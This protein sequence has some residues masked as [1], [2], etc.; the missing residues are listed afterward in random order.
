[1]RSTI[2][3]AG[4]VALLAFSARAQDL[5][6]GPGKAEVETQC[7]SCHSLGRVVGHKD[8]L[9]GWAAIVDNMVGMGAMFTDG[10]KQLITDYLFKNFSDKPAEPAAADQPSTPA[11]DA[12][13]PKADPSRLDIK[14]G[15]GVAA[16]F[17]QEAC[18][19]CH[20][21]SRLTAKGGRSKAE[22]TEV[23]ER[24]VKKGALLNDPKTA[25]VIDYL[26][27]AFPK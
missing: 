11:A 15:E 24:M 6:E 20:A 9:E 5:P 27:A 17:I 8:T 3:A 7:S 23:V 2:I 26:T 12:A 21:L 4:L 22:W 25:M 18:T 1:M 14:L 10:D 16:A 13:A 19:Q